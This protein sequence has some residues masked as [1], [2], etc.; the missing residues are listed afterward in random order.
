MSKTIYNVIVFTGCL[1]LGNEGYVS[2]RKINN[3]KRFFVFVNEQYPD[4]K[5]ANVYD[6]ATRKKLE[7]VKR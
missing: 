1:D 4:W 3:L 2:Y 5:F 6:N 7:C